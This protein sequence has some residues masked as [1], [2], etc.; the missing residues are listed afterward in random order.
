LK[1]RILDNIAMKSLLKPKV[2]ATLNEEKI[3]SKLDGRKDKGYAVVT[4]AQEEQIS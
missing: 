2:A 4:T 1:I 3:V